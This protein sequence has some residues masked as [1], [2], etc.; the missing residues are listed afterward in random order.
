NARARWPHVHFEV[1]EVAVQGPNC[2]P[3][4]SEAIAELD[5]DPDVEVI[6][7]SRGGGSVEGLLPFSNETM[8]RAAAACRPPLVHAFGHESDFPLLDLVADYPAST[9]T[10]A[11]KRIVPDVAQQLSTIDIARERLAGGLARRVSLEQDRLSDF[12][13]RPV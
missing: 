11:A 13:S 12:R 2:V 4:V 5:A 6:V 1:R 9:P 3:Q 7:V 8:V 10:H